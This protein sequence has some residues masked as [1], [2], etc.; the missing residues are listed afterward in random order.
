MSLLKFNTV[1]TVLNAGMAV[2]AHNRSKKAGTEKSKLA[3]TAARNVSVA[4][5]VIG[6]VGIAA[7]L[8]T[9][10]MEDEAE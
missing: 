9:A 10:G 5:V 2:Y 8:A 6:L 4:G 7:G 3:C 1:M